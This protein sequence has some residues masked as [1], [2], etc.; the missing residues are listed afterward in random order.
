M[1]RDVNFSDVHSCDVAVGE[2]LYC[3]QKL[4]L[5][6]LAVLTPRGIELYIMVG[7]EIIKKFNNIQSQR[8]RNSTLPLLPPPL[9]H[10]HTHTHTLQGYEIPKFLKSYILSTRMES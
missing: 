7:E 2:H 8:A 10:I 1:F 4:G 5:C 3:L 9:T 6:R